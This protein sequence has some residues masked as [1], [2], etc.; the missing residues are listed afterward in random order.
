MQVVKSS[1]HAVWLHEKVN[2][3]IRTFSNEPIHIEGKIQ[4]LIT[5]N[6]WTS[7]SANF[8]VVANGLNSLIGREL[9][10]N[11]SLSVTQSSSVQG[12]QVNTIS[13]LFE[14]K[15][16]I[17]KNFPYLISRIGRSKNHVAKSNFHKDY[18]PRHQKGRRIPI[19]L[20]DKVNTE[21][22]KLIDE[23]HIIKFSRC[24]DKY[25]ISP[26]S[27]TIKK[28]QSITLALHTKRLNKAI[29]K[30][31]YQVPN[32]DTLIESFSQTD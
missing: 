19:N 32:M 13:S 14:F 31:K 3:Q 28:D 9:F 15:E 2:P 27:V 12:N 5:S 18:Q 21:L 7:N 17:A 10:D 25:F 1:P 8:T 20:Q 22:K 24:P 29:H 30:N 6:G 26:N 16:H 11:L 23:K 4:S